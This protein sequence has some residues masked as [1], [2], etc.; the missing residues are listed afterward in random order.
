MI[1]ID[2]FAGK[3]DLVFDFEQLANCVGNVEKVLLKLV[4]VQLGLVVE[5][6]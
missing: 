6:H 5:K 2:R 4:R 3:V 1:S